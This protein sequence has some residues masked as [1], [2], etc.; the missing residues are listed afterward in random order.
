MRRGSRGRDGVE[1]LSG[2]AEVTRSP[3]R[4][5]P[6]PKGLESEPVGELCPLLMPGQIREETL[7]RDISSSEVVVQGQLDPEGQAVLGE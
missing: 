4:H 5:V 3:H 6:E 2:I 1:D 7:T